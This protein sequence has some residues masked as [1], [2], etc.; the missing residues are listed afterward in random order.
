MKQPVRPKLPVP[1]ADAAIEW[2]TEAFDARLVDRYTD[3]DRVVYAS[4]EVFG[5]AVGLKDGDDVDPAPR[6]RGV[7]VEVDTDDPDRF[8]QAALRLGATSVFPVADQSYGARGGRIRD[9]FGHEWLLQTP[10]EEAP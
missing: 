9:P 8:E 5:G 1:K 10:M 4:I 3:G 6:D 7:L 2:Y